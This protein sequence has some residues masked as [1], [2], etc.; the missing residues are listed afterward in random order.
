MTVAQDAK[1]RRYVEEGLVESNGFLETEGGLTL[2]Y[3]V[4]ALPG[5]KQSNQVTRRIKAT[6]TGPVLYESCT[7]QQFRRGSI[8]LAPG[9]CSHTMA[10]QAWVQVERNRASTE[11]SV[12]VPA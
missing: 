2:L 7:C 9:A 1:A 8:K 11:R 5:C 12:A 10:V 4:H 3:S 6:S